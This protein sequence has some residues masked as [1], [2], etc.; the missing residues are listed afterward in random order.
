M[1]KVL[2]SLGL[3]VKHHG[4]GR[5]GT[6]DPYEAGFCNYIDRDV[7]LHQVR[8][9]LKVIGSLVHVDYVRAG[10]RW[11]GWSENQEVR[12]NLR[13]RM[14]WWVE[15]TDLCDRLADFTYR[16]EAFPSEHFDIPT[17]WNHK[18]H[19]EPVTWKAMLDASLHL[20]RR[21]V[22]KREGYGYGPDCDHG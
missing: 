19:Y 9:P 21:V 14:R 15:W 12:Y 1:M 10:V 3:D 18:G 16:I 7:V 22:E 5:D 11:L 6:V 4:W 13:S 17:D 8:D 20:S 2:R